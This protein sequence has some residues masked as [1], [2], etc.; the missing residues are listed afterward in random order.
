MIDY[1]RFSERLRATSRWDL[2]REFQEEWGYHVPEGA[3]PWPR[4]SEDEHKAYVRGLTGEDDRFAGVDPSLPIPEALDEWWD[5]PFNS[6]THSARLYW[7]NPEWPP[8]VRP[9]PSGYGVA[10]G[11]QEGDPFVG[12]EDDQRVCVF[13]AENQYCN[14]WGY[15]A[16]EAGQD[17]PRVMVSTEDGWRVQSRS[18]SEFFLQLAAHRLTAHF[19]WTVQLDEDDF[20]GE[21]PFGERLA[22]AYPEMGLLPWWEFEADAMAHGA[23]DTIIWHNRGGYVDWGV[24]IHARSRQALVAV[25]ETLGAKPGSEQSIAPPA[26]EE[27]VHAM[28]EPVELAELLERAAG[29]DRDAV[30]ELIEIL[31]DPSDSRRGRLVELVPAF[32]RGAPDA[33]RAETERLLA[34][35]GDEDAAVRGA[36]PYLLACSGADLIPLL[37][38][39]FENEPEPGVAASLV[40][41]VGRM[42]RAA[43]VPPIGWLNGVLEGSSSGEVRAAAVV[44]LLDCDVEEVSGFHFNILN[45]Q[46]KAEESALDRLPWASE[47]RAELLTTGW[48]ESLAAHVYMAGVM[49]RISDDG[50]DFVREAGELMRGWR[51]VPARLL[52]PMAALLTDRLPGIRAAAVRELAT[53]GPALAPVADALVPMLDDPDPQ[54]AG[55]ALDALARAGDIRCLPAL[56]RDLPYDIERAVAGLAEHSAALVP[57]LRSRLTED[58]L[59]GLRAWGP[60]AEAFLPEL[61]AL[62]ERDEAVTQAAAVLGAIGPGAA[63]ALPALRAHMAPDLARLVRAEAAWAY[64]AISG[65]AAEALNIL[66]SGIASDEAARRLFDLGEA[67]RPALPL[68]PDEPPA[69]CVR[70]RI[71]GDEG[72][73]PQVVDALSGSPVGVLAVRALAERPPARPVPDAVA[74]LKEIAHGRKVVAEAAEP[75]V[76]A[77]DLRLRALATRALARLPAPH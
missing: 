61:V 52:P 53:M 12:P 71:T 26:V 44:A 50:E 1:G 5:L 55:G 51:H 54:L 39:R 36:V 37:Q 58:V 9:D 38:E 43:D 10:E 2:L 66:R 62:L 77:A 74:R 7:T 47:G 14:E 34:L 46:V 17:D 73:L 69:A 29:G 16:A 56:S 32:V 22:A 15:L 19:G 3:A 21:V 70:Y 4:W 11:L 33:V 8:T 30:T 6:F 63:P 60:E 65:E 48:N 13:M 67:A 57:L 76:I 20:P 68:L 31:A 45:E 24:E 40:L 42:C 27:G 75:D 23:P 72:L 28:S 25:L 35:L 59:S 49:M 18:I 41:A 64:W